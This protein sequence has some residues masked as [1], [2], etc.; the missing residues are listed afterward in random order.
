MLFHYFTIVNKLLWT[1]PCHLWT[2]ALISLTLW[3]TLPS[4]FAIWVPSATTQILIFLP[5]PCQHLILLVFFILAI[6]VGLFKSCGF[7]LHFPNAENTFSNVNWLYRYFLLQSTY[8]C[9]LC[10]K[11]N[12]FLLN[13]W[14]DYR[15]PSLDTYPFIPPQDNTQS[16]ALEQ[17]VPR[18]PL[19]GRGLS[20]LM[21]W[22]FG[23]ELM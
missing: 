15:Q 3:E 4:V 18:P 10:I 12:V 6:L 14:G 22:D 23:S 7:N 5:H 20:F 8:S 11:K 9:L 19:S 13:R 16:S 21:C 2:Y 1:S 17:K